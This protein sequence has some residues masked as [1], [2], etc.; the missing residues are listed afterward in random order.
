M[1][2]IVVV[3]VLGVVVVVAY[4][5]GG[6]A[7]IVVVPVIAPVVLVLAELVT[8]YLISVM[9]FVLGDPPVGFT[10]VGVVVAF[11]LVGVAVIVGSLCSPLLFLCL[12]NLSLTILFP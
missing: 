4:V 3:V 7:V 9:L 6:V 11:V 2:V 5:L 1:G 8:D 10:A 12:Q